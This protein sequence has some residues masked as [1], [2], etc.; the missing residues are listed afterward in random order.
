MTHSS[1][2]WQK[3]SP[4]LLA[5]LVALCLFAPS[6]FCQNHLKVISYNIHG[7]APGSDAPT[8][9]VHIIENFIQ[10]D[11]D[12]VGIQEIN[13]IGVG[14][15]SDNQGRAITDSL[16][17]H[18]GRPYYF[19]QYETQLAWDGAYRQFNGIISRYPLADSG[20]ADLPTS[21]FPRKVVWASI[22]TVVGTVNFFNT[23]L[24]GNIAAEQVQV[25]R[26]YIRG[27]EQANPA[28]ASLLTGDFNSPPE[29][30]AVQMLLGDQSD[31]TF[32]D[33][34][35]EANPSSP[36]YTVPAGDPSSRIDYIFYGRAGDFDISASE[37]VFDTPYA[38]GQY[39]SDHYGVMTT[40]VGKVNR[41]LSVTGSCDFP[42]LLPGMH[43]SKTVTVTS[44]GIMPVDISSIANS[45][46][47]FQII[48]LPPFP[49]TLARGDPALTM[50]IAFTP[51]AAGSFED[52][53]TIASNDSV[54][55]HREVVLRGKCLAAIAPVSPGQMYATSLHGTNGT[56]YSIDAAAGTAHAIG[57][58]QIPGV[59][60][61]AVRPS[62]HELY[63]SFAKSDGTSIYR[64]TASTGDAVP[65][66][67]LS[68]GNIGAIAFG[69]DDV[70]YGATTTGGFCRI[71]LEDGTITPV[72]APFKY[73]F[74]GIC[75]SPAGDVLWACVKN[76]TDSTYQINPLSGEVSYVGVT[77]FSAYTRAFAFGAD[78]TLYALVDNGY[79]TT[80]IATLDTLTATGLTALPTGIDGLTAMA[81]STESGT[82]VPR[83][84]LS[85]LPARF[86][87]EQNYP[88]PF[89]PTTVISGQLTADSWVRLVVYDLLGREVSVLANGRFPAGKYSFNLS[90]K[91]M[92]SGV[93]VYRLTAGS[94]SAARKMILAR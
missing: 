79:G 78:R 24:S 89:N 40:F 69:K 39:C 57:A 52:S 10:L 71:N 8:R 94:F 3:L 49:V 26:Q 59:H 12:I 43:Y 20:F 90:G 11:P 83:A 84:V 41:R 44:V 92:A 85:G 15:G 75:M 22:E 29:S 16:S 42:S 68:A 5:I 19:Y 81:I 38:S 67:F 76:K 35:V 27:Q 7:M 88:N 61:L 77:G 93:Y 14:D 63:G 9:L 82:S 31:T 36:G 37:I 65:A 53:V 87:L 23:H 17:S 51:N 4:L 32:A 18:F 34:Y 30:D 56:L 86:A 1:C 25:I 50:T 47:A 45:S 70:M 72:G 21:D 66:G 28:V 64:I 58:M 54:D 91:G 74:A 46:S 13:E 73:G 6:S 62:T 2:E 33:T 60:S 48:G 55:P 80:Y